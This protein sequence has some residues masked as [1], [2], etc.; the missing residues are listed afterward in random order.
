MTYDP[1]MEPEVVIANLRQLGCPYEGGTEC[2]TIWLEG[3]IAGA[4]YT[5]QVALDA[6]QSE[7]RR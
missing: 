4:K 7:F 1:V 6:I 5:G 2:A 3:Y